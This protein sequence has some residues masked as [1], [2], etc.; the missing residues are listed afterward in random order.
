[1]AQIGRSADMHPSA[2][3]DEL[4]ESL[5]SLVKEILQ[6]DRPLIDEL[7]KARR[8]FWEVPKKYKGTSSQ[9]GFFTEYLVFE[10]I[11]TSLEMRVGQP[12]QILERSRSQLGQNETN[13]FVDN[14]E[15]PTI[16]LSHGLRI[17]DPIDRRW[18]LPDLQEAFD[19]ALLTKE[20]NWGVKALIEI[21]AFFDLPGL[22]GDLRRLLRA[23]E[24]YALS[25]NPLFAFI[26]FVEVEKERTPSELKQFKLSNEYTHFYFLP[27]LPQAQ[28]EY[29]KADELRQFLDGLLK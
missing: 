7:M 1:M 24:T 29:Y 4:F 25:R 27:Y 26:G 17:K 15:D 13:Y 10:V 5:R 20:S 16:L 11:R 14:V 28:D 3:M 6:S 8:A 19:I 18:N 22:K 9:M 23:E 12:F 2:I 21:K